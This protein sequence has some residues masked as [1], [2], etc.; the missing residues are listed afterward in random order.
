M[1]KQLESVFSPRLSLK[2]LLS[3]VTLLIVMPTVCATAAFSQDPLLDVQAYR[4]AHGA[5]ILRSFSELL[6]IPNV[7]SDNEN[8]T[9]NAEYLRQELERRGVETQLWHEG[10][11]PPIVYGSRRT[12][13][14][15]TIGIYVH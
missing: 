3:S 12:G 9:K 13:A 7:A 14:N 15:R 2:S 5:E 8:I 4:L 11:A 10:D 6:S 1:I